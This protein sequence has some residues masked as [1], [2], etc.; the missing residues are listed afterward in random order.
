MKVQ[1]E[2]Y[3]EIITYET[4]DGQGVNSMLQIFKNMMLALGYHND[5]VTDAIKYSDGDFV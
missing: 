5:S 1:I 2:L 4:A 3:D